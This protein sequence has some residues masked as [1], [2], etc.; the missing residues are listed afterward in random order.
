MKHGLFFLSVSIITIFLSLPTLAA[1]LLT[2]EK[3][4]YN[5]QTA[6]QGTKITHSFSFRNTGNEPATIEKVSS[7]CGCTVANVSERVV[8][9]GKR[10]EI[11]ATFDTSDFSGPVTKE[12]F[13]YLRG[14]QTPAYTLTMKGSV[15]EELSVTPA[16]LNLGDVKAGVRKT[17]VLTLENRGR[18]TVRIMEIKTAT[19]LMTASAGKRVLKPGESTAIQ[20]SVTPR[21][22]SRFLGG[23]ITI[24]TDSPG[25]GEKTVQVYGMVRK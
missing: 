25:K 24:H 15:T 17:G 20:V 3:P 8:R 5:F 7:S 4:A 1:Q 2:F 16:Q 18:R 21:A 12:I 22:D 23:Y 10:G 11:R 19:N 14:S 13:V 9:P 6:Q